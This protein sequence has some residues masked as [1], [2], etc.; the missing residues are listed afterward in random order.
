MAAKQ[1]N[2]IATLARPRHE[3]FPAFM[4]NDA[5]R[6]K[7][8]TTMLGS[9]TELKHDTVLYAKQIHA[10]MGEGGAPD[11][12]P[13]PPPHGLVQPDVA[14][15][16]EMERLA[17]FTEQGFDR[18]KLFPDSGEEFSRFGMFADAMKHFRI[19]AEKHVAG[20]PL[21]EADWETIRTCNLSYM[22]KPI[23][24]RSV[25]LRPTR[26]GRSPTLL[27]TC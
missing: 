9:Y 15:W 25:G 22:T 3:N 5:F 11:R 21:T 4:S 26:V 14:F 13:P 18:H 6:A 10:E 27:I 19:I 2:V 23:N 17:R 8:I 1:L 24:I 20:T 7:N 16:R 12:K